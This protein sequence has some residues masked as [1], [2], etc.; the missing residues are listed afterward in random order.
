MEKLKMHTP[1]LTAG[2]IEKLAALFPNCVTEARDEQGQLRRS[3]DF[4]QLRQELSDHVVDGPR[5]RYHLDW[6]GKREALLA[7]N[8]PIA[9]T[10]RPCREESLDFDTTKNLFIEGDNLDALKLLQETYLG[11]VKMIYIDPPYNTGNDFIYND[12]FSTSSAEY[13]RQSNQQSDGGEQLIA[14]LESNGRFHSEWLSMLYPRIKIARNFLR[15][16]GVIMISINDVEVPNVR[17]ICDE[18]FGRE[19][20]LGQLIW[21][22]KRG[23]GGGVKTLVTE[24]EYIV[25]Y[26]KESPENAV[27]R[28]EAEKLELNLSDEVGPYRKS[29]ELNKWGAGSARA[30]RPTMYF[31]IPGP[32]GVDVYPIR[33][34]GSE[35]RWRLGKKAMLKI[36]NQ[37]DALF[38]KREDGSFIV[39]EKIRNADAR[40]KSFRTII[41]D[42]GTAADGTA[43]LKELFDGKAPFDFP[44]PTQLLNKLFEISAVEDQDIVLDFFAGSGTTADALLQY[45]SVS[46]C[47]PVFL[48]VQLPEKAEGK[49]PT[50][51]DITKDR[52]RQ[53]GTKIKANN[54][55]NA[56]NLDIGFR[57]LKIDT[58]N[59]QDVY[60]TPAAVKQDDLLSHT[61]NIKP[62]RTPEDLLFQVLVDW[63]VDLSLPIERQTIADK[64]VFFVDG[65]ALA[66]CFEPNIGEELVKELAKRK[67]L[68]AVFRDSSFDNDSTKINVEQ[69][70][71]LLSP[72]TEVKSL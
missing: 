48:L 63:G 26:A 56:P 66:A 14:N 3:I 20:F 11:K 15:D 60:Y 43:R 36:V 44:K 52:L 1:D 27:G 55:T 38:E 5:E 16:D 19:N 30:D 9:K 42:A 34:D 58:S 12:V 39:F 68:R 47:S 51:S 35:G 37:G 61:D 10:L 45:A 21:H 57:V 13:L 64:N 72:E 53:A 23:G 28:Q 4:D 2:N 32:N 17:K 67:P 69:I 54:A 18:I 50:I 65:N 31:P 71:K 22:S 49:F 25:A 46:D 33:N 6:P 70:F 7:A 59:M 24:H 29:R 41:S 40:Y 62:D 8:A